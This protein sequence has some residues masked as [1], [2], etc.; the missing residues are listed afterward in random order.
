MRD[1]IAFLA[2]I[3]S[4]I[5]AAPS[6]A[7]TFTDPGF[8]AVPY[9][10][11]AGPQAEPVAFA[12]APDGR[13]YIADKEGLVRVAEAGSDDPP[14]TLL[15][16]SAVVNSSHDRGLL[17]IALAADFE[18]SGSIYLLS[19]VESDPAHP[20]QAVGT[21]ARLAR[22]HVDPDD[23]QPV[24]AP[25]L[26]T[27]VGAHAAPCP[28]LPANSD[29]IPAEG[30]THVIGTVRT[31]PADGTLWVG[32]GDASSPSTVDPLAL[33]TLDPTSLRGKI[34]HVAPDGRGLPGHAFCPQDGNLAD[35]CTKV[36]A[37]GFRNPFRFT[38]SPFGVI[39]GDVG[40]NTREEIDRVVAGGDYGWPCYEGMSETG[41][42]FRTPGYADLRGCGS[43]YAKEG[44]AGG[45]R[46]PLASYVHTGHGLGDA[47]VGGVVAD[48]A[49]YPAAIRGDLLLGDYGRRTLMRLPL[50]AAG[51]VEGAMQPFAPGSGACAVD[52]PIPLDIQ[53]GPGGDLLVLDAATGRIDRIRYSPGNRQPVAGPMATPVGGRLP[54]TIGFDAHGCDPN[55]GD[56]L[57]YAW[58]FGDGTTGTG[59]APSH[60]YTSAPPDGTLLARVTV[61]DEHG[62]TGFGSVQVAPGDGPPVPVIDR[63]VASARVTGGSTVTLAG[64]ATDAED[65]AEPAERLH[66]HVTLRHKGH[67]HGV[68]DGDGTT[69]TFRALADHDADS[70]YEITLT[71]T[72]AAGLPVST[73]LHL[74]PAVAPLMLSSSPPGAPLSFAGTAVRAPYL[75]DAAVGFVTSISAAERFVSGGRTEV[76]AGWSDGGAR[77]HTIQVGSGPHALTATY[78]AEQAAEN[79]GPETTVDTFA[80][81]TTIARGTASDADG[82]RT[83]EVA[84]RLRRVHGHGCHWWS[85]RAGRPARAAQ[86][87][88]APRFLRALLSGHGWSVRWKLPLGGRLR[89][90]TQYVFEVRSS[91]GAGRR[92]THEASRRARRPLRP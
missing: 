75:H 28:S 89:S 44:T 59:P 25:V 87:C 17:G 4:L 2:V 71:A 16:L 56:T 49:A 48:D 63:P 31:D 92:T 8:E 57:S 27:L 22:V 61:T 79:L 82:V 19:T 30:F 29:C 81:G 32:S 35:A 45:A 47:V 21:V 12:Q 39:A 26:T 43:L 50:G 73:T 67:L 53:A 76:F 7:T 83:V 38:L 72:D 15:D 69:T 20:D 52:A 84:L 13:V 77:L 66:W 60:T 37:L 54:L 62:A 41:T 70:H 51:G 58:D 9:V 64:H 36:F 34:L 11:S 78:R 74:M 23:P 3:A 10:A 6:G 46:L 80:P 91:D 1:R 33:G 68:A 90:R 85:R 88:A 42:P 24:A 40:W 86:S 55:P 65:G 18:Q 5:L 14:R